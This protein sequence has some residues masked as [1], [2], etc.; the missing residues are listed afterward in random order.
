MLNIK[1]FFGKFQNAQAKE[2]VFRS[3]VQRA[4][5][6][7]V[8]F[9]V[10]IESISVRGGII[11]IKDI[12]QAARSAIFIKKQPIVFLINKTQQLYKIRDIK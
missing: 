9:G 5:G 10:K 4:I 7:I 3:A 8:G 12:S 2:V 1:E 11:S 6:D